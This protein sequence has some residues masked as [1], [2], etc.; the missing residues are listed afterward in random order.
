[1]LV[2]INTKH[3]ES[4]GERCH[5]GLRMPALLGAALCLDYCL[6]VKIFR[7]GTKML[8]RMGFA[9]LFTVIKISKSLNLLQKCHTAPKC[10]FQRHCIMKCHSDILHTLV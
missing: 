7:D 4:I 6:S 8:E 10:V 1:M 5:K 3:P 2:G 9:I